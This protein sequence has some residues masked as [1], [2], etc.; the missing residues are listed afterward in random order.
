MQNLCGSFRRAAPFVEHLSKNRKIYYKVTK[1][2]DQM[3]FSHM[4]PFYN[5]GGVH[6]TSW[7]FST[8]W[9]FGLY[10]V[11][12]FIVDWIFLTKFC[13]SDPSFNG[14]ILTYL[15]LK[16]ETSAHVQLCDYSFI[17]AIYKFHGV[18]LA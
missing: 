12:I 2:K 1:E 9:K 5:T 15:Y 6:S 4:V 16:Y 17:H 11:Y 8:W 13:T 14:N 7:K 18:V 3:I 10:F